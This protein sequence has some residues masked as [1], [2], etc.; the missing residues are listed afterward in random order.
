MGTLICL[1][2]HQLARLVF[3]PAGRA[4][5]N[6]ARVPAECLVITIEILFNLCLFLFPQ[7]VTDTNCASW[8]YDTEGMLTSY[9]SIRTHTTT[10]IA[11]NYSCGSIR[12]HT[13]TTIAY[14]AVAV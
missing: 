1:K 10:T 5:R 14:I 13:T 3:A 12:T 7:S 4:S 6:F 11:Y 8:D 2:S 9:G